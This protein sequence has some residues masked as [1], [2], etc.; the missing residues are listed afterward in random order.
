MKIRKLYPLGCVITAAVCILCFS[1]NVEYFSD[2]FAA[3]ESG[4]FGQSQEYEQSGEELSG[5]KPSTA[6]L[7]KN[8]GDFSFFNICGANRFDC[9]CCRTPVF[10]L[11]TAVQNARIFERFEAELHGNRSP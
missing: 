9:S 11:H 5:H 4:T 6:S 2:V 10:A 7:L 8:S 3:S 1:G